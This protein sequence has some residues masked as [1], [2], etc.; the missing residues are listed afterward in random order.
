MAHPDE[1]DAVVDFLKRMNALTELSFARL[2]P[3]L[4]L[5]PRKFT[6]WRGRNGKAHEH[7][8]QVPRDH[9]LE[10]LEKQAIISYAVNH[11]LEGYRSLTFL[12]MDTDVAAVAPATT[13]RVLKKAGLIGHAKGQP[14]KKGT[15]FIQPLPPHE[16]WQ[17]G[18]PYLNIGSTCYF[19][20]CVP[21]DCSRAMPA[22]DIRPAMREIDAEIVI[23]KAREVHSE[24]RPR[25]ISGQGSRFKSREFKAF[26]TQWQA[27]HVTT[28]P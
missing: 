21:D 4:E 11:P 5:C 18:F 1:R 26:I 6:R 28:S 19:R 7:P 14:W 23:Q 15:G 3:W 25:S 8:A 10:P 24:A 17:T 9:W 2:L 13:Y 12:M 22:W 27:S 16:H 20:C